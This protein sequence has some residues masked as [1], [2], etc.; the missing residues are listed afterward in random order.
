MPETHRL[1]NGLP[2]MHLYIHRPSLGL[3]SR[4]NRA[5]PSTPNRNTTSFHFAHISHSPINHDGLCSELRHASSHYPAQ[6]G[7]YLVSGLRYH[8]NCVRG[9][10]VSVWRAG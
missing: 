9:C 10:E 4:P 2:N 6:D 5:D 1:D 7:A 8:H 3:R